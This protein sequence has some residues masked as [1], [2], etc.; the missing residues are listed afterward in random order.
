MGYL[1]FGLGFMAG[2][3]TLAFLLLTVV[4]KIIGKEGQW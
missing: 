1:E 4:P 3:S 2:F